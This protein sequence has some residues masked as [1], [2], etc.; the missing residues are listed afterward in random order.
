MEQQQLDILTF[1]DEIIKAFRPIE[2]LF[3]IMDKSPVEVSGDVNNSYGEI[4]LVLCGNF[5]RKLELILS[6]KSQET[7]NDA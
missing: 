6:S 3:R 2:Q 5:R 1:M 7:S 4:G